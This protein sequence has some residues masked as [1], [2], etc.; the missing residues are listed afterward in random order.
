MKKHI[1]STIMDNNIN[2]ILYNILKDDELSFIYLGQFNNPVLGMTTELWKGYMSKYANSEGHRNKLSFLMV[3]CFQ[4]ILRYG[5]SGRN[6]TE[7]RGEIFIVRRYGNSYYITSGNYI[8]NT[9]AEATKAKLKRVNSMSADELKKIF[10]ETLT[11]KQLSKEGGAGLGFVEMIRKTKEKLDFKFT[12]VDDNRSFFY[13][14]IRL[15]ISDEDTPALDI[16]QAE[17]IKNIMEQHHKFIALKGDFDRSAVNQMLMMAESNIAQ[18]DSELKIQSKVYHIMVEMMQNIS[19]HAIAEQTGE[20]NGIFSFGKNQDNYSLT[21]SNY[22][23]NNQVDIIA[24][25]IDQLNTK[26]HSQLNEYY[27]QVLRNG[28]D[29]MNMASGLGLIDIAR[30]SKDGI[31]YFFYHD[32]QQKKLFTIECM[33]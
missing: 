12:K 11:N 9:K 28:H 5:L 31:K 4:N 24:Q 14:Q 27:R 25:Y 15:K 8:D 32:G 33:I 2:R 19:K 22:V 29:D 13:F 7:T 6:E 1:I 20:H 3:E 21:A 10:V 23:E 30:E 17:T 16:S 18:L 26:D